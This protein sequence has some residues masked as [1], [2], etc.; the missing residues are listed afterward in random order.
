[1]LFSLVD[2]AS[3][4]ALILILAIVINSLHSLRLFEL[5][6]P[7]NAMPSSYSTLDTAAVELSNQI[8]HRN[9]LGAEGDRVSLLEHNQSELGFQ[10]A[11]RKIAKECNQT[12]TQFV[13]KT[14]LVIVG[15][16]VSGNVRYFYVMLNL[17]LTQLLATILAVSCFIFFR[18]NDGQ[19]ASHMFALRQSQVT[20]VSLLLVTAFRALIIATLGTSFTQYLRYVLRTR[21]LQVELIES[22]FKM[23]SDAWGLFDYKIMRHAPLL[24]A[25]A[26]LSWIIPLVT[27]YPSGALT[28]RFES[29]TFTTGLNASIMNPRPVNTD[30][31][32]LP[33]LAQ[34]HQGVYYHVLGHGLGEGGYFGSTYLLVDS[35]LSDRG[36]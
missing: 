6:Q 5:K 32:L 31:A 19:E 25:A 36:D 14:P 34:V 30:S 8:T 33:T 15:C 4:L 20:N 3:R 18:L 10:E 13:W 21:Y 29:H 23:R 26:A 11:E 12:P 9:G 16:Y 2:V 7:V 24:F 27:I 1:M 17:M 35:S 22:L 28:I